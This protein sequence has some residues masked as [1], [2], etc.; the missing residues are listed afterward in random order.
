MSWFAQISLKNRALIALVTIAA[1]VF[2]ILGAGQLKQELMP[3]VEFPAVAVVTT[4]PGATPEVVN[5]DVTVPVETVLRGVPELVQTTG[6][7]STNSSLVIAEFN[8]GIDLAATEQKVERAINRI[9]GTLPETAD[10]QAISGGIEDIPVIQVALTPAEGQTADEAAELVE[11]T[12][13]PELEDIDGVRSAEVAG[14][15]GERVTIDADAAKLAAGGFSTQSIRDAIDN[16][17]TLIP[18]G[19]VTQDGQSLAVQTGSQ[20]TS[21]EAIAKLPLPASQASPEPQL[22]G[23]PPAAE[24]PER[25]TIGDVA[26]VA[27]EPNPVTSISRVNGEPAVTIAVTKTSAANT[28]EISQA[29]QR[30][31]DENSDALQGGTLTVIFDQAPYIQESVKTLTTEGLLGLVFAVLVILLFLFSVRATL[32]TAISIPTSVLLTIIAIWSAEYTLNILT[33]GALTITIGRV[34]DDSIVVIENIQRHLEIPGSRSRAGVIVDAVKEVAGAITASTITTVAVFLPMA[35]VSGMVGELFRPFAF[36]V[37][38]ALAASLFVSLTIVPV[39]AY[40]F[41]RAK[42][43]RAERS[44]EADAADEAA[45]PDEQDEPVTRL[46]KAYHPV[47]DWTLK[48]PVATLVLAVLVFAGTMAATPLMKTNFLGAD[49]QNAV[50]LT[51]EL[52]PGLTLDEQLTKAEEVEKA[53]DTVDGVESVQVTLGSQLGPQTMFGGS[54]EG[55]ITYSITNDAA[56]DQEQITERIR[57]AVDPLEGEFSLGQGGPGG[58]S[59]IAIKVSA[60]DPDT[61]R[62]ANDAL[63]DALKNRAELLEVKSSLATSRPFLE[64]AVDRTKAAELGLTETAV[65]GMIAG[66]MMPQQVGSIVLENTTT[67]LYLKDGESPGTVDEVKNLA[68]MT[69]QGEKKVSELAAVQIADGPVSIETESGVRGASITMLPKGDDLT[70]ASQAV[71]EVLDAAE[72]PAGASA[73][74]GGVLSD[75]QEAFEQLG[76]ALLAAILIVY[77]VMVAT[78]KSLLQPLLLLISVPFAATGAL[79][80]MLATGTPLG[81]ASLI[82][83]LMLI[84]VVVTNAIVLVDLINQYREKGMSLRQAVEEGSSKRLRPILMTALATILALTPMGLG[85]T[86]HGGGFI[87]KPLAIVVIGGLLSSTVLTLVVLPTLYYIVE[88]RRENRSRRRAMRAEHK[89]HRRVKSQREDPESSDTSKPYTEGNAV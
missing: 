26:S 71:T 63:V 11:R 5:K 29:V 89:T 16:S 67:T 78:F 8:Y 81:V 45:V 37:S 36:T 2:G 17:G 42:N 19:E 32:V 82:G 85:L 20:L 55:S 73:S 33:L 14:A 75:Q 64:V 35:F 38:F 46:Q 76:L 69:P 48:R 27:L 60:P 50:S 68:L 10:W 4:Y 54:I 6:T 25:V 28:V 7:S 15:R 47:I 30:A 24:T 62:E 51:Q 80:L 43:A 21:V 83:V 23:L 87:S 34:V 18:G 31:L 53:L 65:A 72:L 70:T 74:I 56:A 86:G 44:A 1:S 3:S 88:N 49:G 77:I 13:V 79:L 84:G 61:L 9:S 12:V 40:W 52:K 59:Q 39:L 58:T 57:E 22:P 41:L 66:R